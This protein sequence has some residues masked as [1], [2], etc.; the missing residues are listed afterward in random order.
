MYEYLTV[1]Y[2]M[3]LVAKEHQSQRSGSVLARGSELCPMAT[4]QEQTSPH[5]AS[6]LSSSRPAQ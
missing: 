2:N 1:T 5:R 4:P 6:A 3:F